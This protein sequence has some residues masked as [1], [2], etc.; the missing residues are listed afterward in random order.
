MTMKIGSRHDC[1]RAVL[2][3]AIDSAQQ[4]D[5]VE[6][7][8]TVAR[9]E[10]VQARAAVRFITVGDNVKTVEGPKQ[11]LGA[12]QIHVDGVDS[13]GVGRVDVEGN[14]IQFAEL[15]RGDE[16][17]FG[18]DGQAHPR[19]LGLGNAIHDFYRKTW[20]DLDRDSRSGGGRS[21]NGGERESEAEDNDSHR[22]V[23]RVHP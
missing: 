5:L 1:V 15:V 16:A 6:V 3:I 18:I 10:T 8:A 7:I 17:T 14:S 23:N 12:A 20:W 13:G 4:A 11:A 9:E 2:A 22:K 19:A 21:T